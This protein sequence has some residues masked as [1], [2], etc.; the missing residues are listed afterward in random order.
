M[1]SHINLTR[2]PR[3]AKHKSDKR[4]LNSRFS[5]ILSKHIEQLTILCT[6]LFKLNTLGN[7]KHI[8]R[9]K[10]QL[11]TQNTFD[12]KII[13]DRTCHEPSVAFSYLLQVSKVRW[14]MEE[15]VAIRYY[16]QRNYYYNTILQFL[17]KY[18]G[19]KMSKHTL[20]IRLRDY[21]LSKRN[22]IVNEDVLND[23]INLELPGCG[24]R[25]QGYRAMWR[26]IHLKYGINVPRWTVQDLL[27]EID[28]EGVCGRQAH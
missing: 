24:N 5:I 1:K 11:E 3:I 23:F 4:K 2:W 6:F 16:F 17:D 14:K 26:R 27:R 9:H 22:R 8:W 21:G 13:N 7:I 15:E 12:K 19:I 28:P 20:L 10:K 25:L 18:H